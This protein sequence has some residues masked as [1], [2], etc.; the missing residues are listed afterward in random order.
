MKRLFFLVLLVISVAACDGSPRRYSGHYVHG[1][2]V[3]TFQPCGSER[4]YWVRGSIK[5][6]GE[7]RESHSELT[8]R[9]YQEIYVEMTGEMGPKATEG[10]PAEYDGQFM[11]GTIKII[12]AATTADCEG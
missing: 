6:L 4:V 1:G 2:E 10:F 5:L 8:D 3:E 9:P 11:I 7:L 12:R